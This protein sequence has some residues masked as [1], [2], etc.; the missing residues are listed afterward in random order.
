MSKLR[1]EAQAELYAQ[2]TFDVPYKPT[3]LISIDDLIQDY[4]EE[5]SPG[6]A[7]DTNFSEKVEEKIIDWFMSDLYPKLKPYEKQP[8]NP[9]EY[10]GNGALG[11]YALDEDGQRAVHDLVQEFM[12]HL[13]GAEYDYEGF[14]GGDWPKEHELPSPKQGKSKMELEVEQYV[15]QRFE[16]LT[17]LIG[18]H[19]TIDE[20]AEELGLT[21]RDAEMFIEDMPDLNDVYK[22]P[23]S[24]EARSQS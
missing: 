23:T 20:L 3:T 12:Y 9:S 11:V 17:D 7:G 24:M 10:V 1:V 2:P 5:L 13:A 15:R 18:R 19:P 6:A 14:K 21:V 8:P 16:T 4:A 22:L